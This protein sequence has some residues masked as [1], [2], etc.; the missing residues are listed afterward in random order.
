MEISISQSP[1]L[2]QSLMN[3]SFLEKTAVAFPGDEETF[4]LQ[5]ILRGELSAIEAYDRVIEKF[6]AEQYRV[7]ELLKSLVQDHEEAAFDL[8]QILRNEGVEPESDS[9]AWGSIVHAVVISAGLFGEAGAL[10][11]L[12][13]GEEYGLEQYKDALEEDRVA[14]SKDYIRFRSIPTQ[15]LH[16]DR[17][18]AFLYLRSVDRSA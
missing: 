6:G 2:P 13:R 15:Q 17:L 4:I 18:S 8:K 5:K 11:A 12:K 3:D 7:V 9:G 16:I 14:H 1:H 10:R